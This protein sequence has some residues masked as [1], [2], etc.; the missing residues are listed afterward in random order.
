VRSGHLAGAALDVVDVEPLPADSVLRGVE[1]IT[2]YSHMAGQTA[3]A[4]RNAGLDGARELVAALAGHPGS[5]VNAHL[6]TE[7]RREHPA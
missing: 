7:P 6:I 3:E 5:S 2:V 4:R 1:G